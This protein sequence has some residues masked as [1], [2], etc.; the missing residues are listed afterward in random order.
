MDMFGMMGGM[1]ENMNMVSVFHMP[2]CA[3]CSP[4]FHL[5]DTLGEI[6][7]KGNL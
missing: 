6:S 1:M 2:I 4:I 3:P 7:L 5:L